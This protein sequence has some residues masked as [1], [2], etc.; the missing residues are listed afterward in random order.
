MDKELTFYPETERTRDLIY[1]E[2]SSCNR[3]IHLLFQESPTV[4]YDFLLQA[5]RA[6][7][8]MYLSSEDLRPPVDFLEHLLSR[9]DRLSS[10]SGLAV[11][12]WKAAGI[13]LLIRSVDAVY[14]LTSR[15]SEVLL[16]SDRRIVPIAES[17]AG[18]V[19][20]LH[21]DRGGAQQELF[22]Q[23]LSGLFSVLKLDPVR[24]GG[25]DLILGCSEGEKDAV[26][27]ALSGPIWLGSQMVEEGR[28]ARRSVASQFVS[29]RILAVRFGAFAAAGDRIANVPAERSLR[30]AA[31]QFHRRCWVMAGGA[32]VV[33]VLIG[34]L[35]RNESAGPRRQ[36]SNGVSK[37]GSSAPARR[38]TD[39][40]GGSLNRLSPANEQ[41]VK[42]TEAWR[43]TYTGEVTSSPVLFEGCV[44]FGCR[45]G[46]M[47]ALERG[48]GTMVWKFSA[49][50]GIGA[51]P[52]VRGGRVFVADYNGEVYAVDG[53]TGKEVWT[54][55]VPMRVVSS[56]EAIGDR[57]VVGC[58]DGYA[59]CFS[60]D[61]GKTLWKRR[62][63]GR[64]RG[65]PASAEEV[66][67]LPSYDGYLYAL[68]AASGAVVWRSSLG[69]PVSAS[70]AVQQG[71]VVV[72]G[73]DGKVYGLDAA[74]GTERWTYATGAAVKSS[75]AVAAGRVF[76]GSNDRFLYCLNLA[77][78]SMVW[79]FKTGDFVLARPLVQDGV[80]Y[81]G[82]YDSRLYAFEASSGRLL[83]SFE[84]AGQVYSSPA[85]DDENVY[86]GTNRG[87]FICLS[88][89]GERTF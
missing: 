68:S 83:G 12:N 44:V 41:D 59:Y 49:T 69:G 34:V 5:Y 35:W 79:K 19:E 78:G 75:V 73:A 22:P 48:T 4:S 51:S 15:E 50:A 70:P 33:A 81:A 47:Y 6:T 13:H 86:F 42:L 71:V 26:L 64:I 38:V 52:V 87:D 10:E 54:R 46:S 30:I 80:V 23:S 55:K 14:V 31:K 24:I 67:F 57:V 39:P 76:V 62:T 11:E 88:R 40:P 17:G 60:T 2:Y 45:D 65:S 7:I 32:V 43:K 1:S 61:D 36:A 82:G 27:E 53:R 9:F 77:D 63:N 56:P 89:R 28:A 84:T 21:L 20:T 29:H 25:K 72:G 85:G 66:I 8:A 16:C 18:G 58:F 3:S 37:T 74:S